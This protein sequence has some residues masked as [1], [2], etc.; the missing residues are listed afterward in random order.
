MLLKVHFSVLIQVSL[1]KAIN[2]S[3]LRKA[4]ENWEEFVP[5]SSGDMGEHVQAFLNMGA[6][7]HAG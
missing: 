2:D 7:A 6:S 5:D 1:A 3:D 4:L